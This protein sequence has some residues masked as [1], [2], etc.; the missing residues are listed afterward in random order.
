MIISEKKALE[1]AFDIIDINLSPSKKILYSIANL[2]E[3]SGHKDNDR[4]FYLIIEHLQIK[5]NEVHNHF[6]EY[7]NEISGETRN[8]RC[9]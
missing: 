9:K 8:D 5:L 2:L 4:I 1:H 7:F 6:T 3:R